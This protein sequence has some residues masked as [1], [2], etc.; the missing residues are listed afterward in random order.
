MGQLRFDNC[1]LPLLYSYAGHH[2]WKEKT[3]AHNLRIGTLQQ[4]QMPFQCH[5]TQRNFIIFLFLNTRLR[6]FSTFQLHRT[7]NKQISQ[8]ELLA[9]NPFLYTIHQPSTLLPNN[10]IVAPSPSSGH[11]HRHLPPTITYKLQVT[12]HSSIHHLPWTNL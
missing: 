3:G 1:C 4:P 11:Q 7:H 10:T 8:F 12:R 9:V 2:S 5:Q 6:V